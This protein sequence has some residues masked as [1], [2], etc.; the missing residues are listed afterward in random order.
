M[1]RPMNSVFHL[2]NRQHAF[3]NGILDDMVFFIRQKRP[4]YEVLKFVVP[5]GLEP[6]TT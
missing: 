3:I 2:K 6:R 5:L 1:L 4:R